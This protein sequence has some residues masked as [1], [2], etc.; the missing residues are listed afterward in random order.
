MHLSILIC[1]ALFLTC[2]AG[3]IVL[4]LID[5]RMKRGGGRHG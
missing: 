3:K 2:V 5:R 1:W 4:S